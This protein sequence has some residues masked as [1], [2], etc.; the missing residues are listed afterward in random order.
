[1]HAFDFQVSRRIAALGV[2]LVALL[3]AQPAIIGPAT[4]T[5]GQTLSYQL[6]DQG[7]P[8]AGVIWTQGLN[9][10]RFSGN[11]YATKRHY[12]RPRQQTRYC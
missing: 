9:P 8:V 11:D 5:P 12:P 1:M 4:G 6:Q 3:A 7:K 2:G 10:D